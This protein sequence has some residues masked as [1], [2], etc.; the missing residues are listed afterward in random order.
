MYTYPSGCQVENTHNGQRA[1]VVEIGGAIRPYEVGDRSV[2]SDLALD[3]DGRA[4]ARL[5]GTDERTVE[6]WVDE[7]YPIIELYTGDTQAADR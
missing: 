1:I 2:F 4:W 6:L 3:A 7:S 5:G